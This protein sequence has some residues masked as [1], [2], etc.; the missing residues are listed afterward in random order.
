MKPELRRELCDLALV[1]AGAIPGAL[2]RWRLDSL[3][4]V[5]ASGMRG[6]VS[7][8]FIA[9]MIGCLLIGLVL[10]PTTGRPRLVLAVGIGFCGSLTTFSAWM[11][12]VARTLRAG[13]GLAA[14]GVLGLSLVGGLVLVNLGLGLGQVLQHQRR[15]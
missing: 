12:A 4:Q 5:V 6:A 13:E 3:G 10:S 14:S 11:L 8:E 7:A 2:L 9:N 15:G 1:A